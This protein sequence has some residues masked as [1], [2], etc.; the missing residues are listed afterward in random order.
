[1]H[2]INQPMEKAMREEVGIF[3]EQHWLCKP[4]KE[5]VHFIVTAKKEEEGIKPQCEKCKSEDLVRNGGFLR[6]RIPELR[7]KG[8]RSPTFNLCTLKEFNKVDEEEKEKFKYRLANDL[9]NKKKEER[10]EKKKSKEVAELTEAHKH[11]VREAIK[12]Y[13]KE[14]LPSKSKSTRIQF[15]QQFEYWEEK[16]GSFLLSE[17][18]PLAIKEARDS[19]ETNKRSNSTLN[20]Y[21]AS[22]SA[23]LGCCVKDF[24]W[25][26]ENP[27]A[28][29]RKKP[30]PKN[31]IR[32][33]SLEEKDNLLAECD[34]ELK[35]AVKLALLTG[36]RKQEIWKLR[37]D[38]I[39]WKHKFISFYET[40]TGIP[41][42][43]PM[44]QEMHTILSGRAKVNQLKSKYVFPSPK[45][46]NSPNSFEKAWDN[47][48]RRSGV[49]DFRWHDLRHTSASYMVMAGIS[50]RTVAD[51]L[52]HANVSMTFKYAHLSPLHLSDALDLLSDE[53]FGES[54]TNVKRLG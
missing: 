19:L 32:F 30:E 12:E 46:V 36:A 27:C 51:I 16:F 21:L 54:K 6:V 11:T 40:K 50:L 41:R 5:R 13:E 14:I 31:R 38:A 49:K 35:D 33:L 22:F 52:G 2:N 18:T 1:M 26:D 4:C 17:L 42:S 53:L 28:K 9:Y 39:N 10:E 48:L 43:V 15:V 37:Y 8:K 29:I 23:V 20:R 47:A 25:M 3:E 24:L 45:K 7:E 44:S 34:P